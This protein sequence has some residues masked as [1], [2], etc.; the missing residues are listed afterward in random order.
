MDDATETAAKD[1]SDCN[2]AGVPHKVSNCSGGIC[3][4]G[5][6]APPISLNLATSLERTEVA[7]A[8]PPVLFV[9]E[10]P[11]ALERPP[12]HLLG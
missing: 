1:S 11:A 8:H 10:I 4:I 12:R 5:A 9:G 7:F 3:H 2:D 6:T